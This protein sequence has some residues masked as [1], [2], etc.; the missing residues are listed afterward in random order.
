LTEP[1][2]LDIGAHEGQSLQQALECGMS[3]V[4]AFE[5]MPRE[6]DLLTDRF[7]GDPRVTLFNY[8]LSD[9]TG[10]REVFGTND[11][12][13]A[14]VYRTSWVPAD[15]PTTVC[16][17][18]RAT[19]WFDEHL[20]DSGPVFA[21]LNCEGSEVDILS[22]LERSGRIWK[23]AAVLVAFDIALVAGQGHREHAIRNR[24]G[25][26]GFVGRLDLMAA[27]PGDNCLRSWLADV[28]VAA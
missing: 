6:F 14:S 25:H 13:E 17:F 11:T 4:Y 21:K 10:E 16:D 2:F 15:A 1:V 19:E 26:I 7:G 12:F 24:L 9:A 3:H 20:T 18:V 23:L 22:D 8:G 5:P 28:A 27:Y